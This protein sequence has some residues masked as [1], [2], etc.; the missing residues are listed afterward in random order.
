MYFVW[1][2]NGG[3]VAATACVFEEFSGAYQCRWLYLLL[4]HV[5]T[6]VFCATFEN[7][8]SRRR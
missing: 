6:A 4:S 8:R 1:R 7:Q 3:Y 5:A 2:R